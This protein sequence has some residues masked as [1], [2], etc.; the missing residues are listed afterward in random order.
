MKKKLLACVIIII[1]GIAKIPIESAL[2]KQLV[3]KNIQNTA[4]SADLRNKLPQLGFMASLG[5]LRSL[6]ASILDL[7]AHIAFEENDWTNNEQLYNIITALQPY[8]ASYWETGAWH[9]ARN[10]RGHYQYRSP[11][12]REEKRE[13]LVDYFTE[14]GLNLLE[15]GIKLNPDSPKLHAE[16]AGYLTTLSEHSIKKDGEKAAYHYIEAFRTSKKPFYERMAA[17]EWAK[18]SDAEQKGKAYEILIRHFNLY[19]KNQPNLSVA[20]LPQTLTA[21]LHKLENELQ[22][23]E[24]QRVLTTLIPLI[25]KKSKERNTPFDHLQKNPTTRN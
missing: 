12:L 5:G 10:A 20:S 11:E 16:M 6:V 1:F 25:E 2:S 17:Y 8:R 4:I 13:A 9:R 7:K 21:T 18:L 14:S 3:E 22:I 24:M 19:T 15:E 23:P